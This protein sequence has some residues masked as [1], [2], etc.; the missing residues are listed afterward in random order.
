MRRR[1]W[2]H[3]PRA[4]NHPKIVTIRALYRDPM[5]LRRY[6]ILVSGLVESTSSLLVIFFSFHQSMVQQY[7]KKMNKKAVVDRLGCMTSVN[8]WAE[9]VIYDELTINEH[10]KKDSSFCI[11]L[12]EVRRGCLSESNANILK[13]RVIQTSPVDK[14][15]ELCRLGQCPVYLFPI[16]KQC[17]SFNNG[18]LARVQSPVIQVR[19]CD[20]VDET[21]SCHKWGA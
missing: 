2:A 15:D 17:E 10:Q 1:A 20:E 5:P 14:F 4:A 3:S 8:I 11:L 12:D 9:T 16:R 18:M 7:S 19:C 13:K 21:S 6:L